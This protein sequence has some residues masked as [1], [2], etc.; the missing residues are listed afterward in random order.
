[1]G[2]KNWAHHKLLGKLQ[3]IFGAKAMTWTDRHFNNR[4]ISLKNF[5]FI[6]GNFLLEFKKLWQ[7]LKYILYHFVLYQHKL[8]SCTVDCVA[9]F[10]MQYVYVSL[11]YSKRKV[12]TLADHKFYDSGSATTPFAWPSR[13][14][15]HP[16]CGSTSG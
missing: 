9:P 16:S 1:M 6:P 12:I 11:S 2:M 7:N 8:I 4:N 15:S 13:M 14:C 3:S 10:L 5:L